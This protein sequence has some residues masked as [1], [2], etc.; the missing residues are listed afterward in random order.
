MLILR[1]TLPVL[2]EKVLQAGISFLLIPVLLITLTAT[3][4][5]GCAGS[6]DA[7]T[8]PVGGSGQEAGTFRA[9]FLDVGK[10]DCIL[11]S[12]EGRY[13]LV[14][15]GYEETAD[16]V[17]D[18]LR[19]Y[20]VSSLDAMVITHYDKDHVGG[21]AEIAQEIPVGT[22]YL[23]DYTGDPDKCADLLALID[24]Q[25][26][27]AVQVSEDIRFSLGTAQVCVDAALIDYD[28]AEENDNDASLLVEIF[29]GED[30]WFLPGD[31]EEEAI[32]A[33]LLA[34]AR[35]YD[36]LKM[37]HHGRKEDNTAGLIKA[38]S[39]QIAVIT[40]SPED[41]ASPK[42]LKKLEKKKVRVLR[43]SENGS[44]LVTGYGI[45]K[46]DIYTEK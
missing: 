19:A 6:G 40:D 9:V 38:V 33:W 14:D 1:K 15:A 24:A 21:A 32:D 8:P 22:F 44:I 13:M 17:L 39:P 3:G 42:V 43:T 35:E 34:R 41:D 36:I 25:D 23:P 27:S 31:I 26:L 4:I 11:L 16:E 28:P 30:S 46:Y 2:R 20:G 12:T 45:G 10:G 5:S 29:Y 18:S 7:D 37:P